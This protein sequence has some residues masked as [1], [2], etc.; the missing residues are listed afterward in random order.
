MK[1]QEN[2]WAAV[3]GL[4]GGREGRERVGDAASLLPGF[5]PFVPPG[6]D[7]GEERGREVRGAQEGPRQEEERSEDYQ[8]YSYCVLSA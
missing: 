8:T 4:G 5:I 2:H 3:G 7:R 6:R 1:R